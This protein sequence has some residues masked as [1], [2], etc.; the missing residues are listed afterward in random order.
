MFYSLARVLL[1]VIATSHASE[2]ALRA[3]VV[4]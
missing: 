2:A 3:K 4:E 1:D